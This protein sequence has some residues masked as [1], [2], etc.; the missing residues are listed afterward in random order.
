MR[1]RIRAAYPNYMKA[2]KDQTDDCIA[3]SI[4]IGESLVKYGERLAARYGRGAPK[5]T[6][7]NFEK[8]AHL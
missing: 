4:L 3:Y 1:V 2:L 7:A 8:G 6:I 5:I